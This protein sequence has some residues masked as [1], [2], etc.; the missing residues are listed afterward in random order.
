M[1]LLRARNSISMCSAKK[2]ESRMITNSTRNPEETNVQIV[3]K[4]PK[5]AAEAS[6]LSNA[7]GVAVR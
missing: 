7:D 3:T 2:Y 5:I 6:K 4:S 1:W